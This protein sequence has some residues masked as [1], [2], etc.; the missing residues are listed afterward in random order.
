MIDSESINQT[1]QTREN[2]ITGFLEQFGKFMG[3][4]IQRTVEVTGRQAHNTR[5]FLR[6]THETI[7][8]PLMEVGTSAQE[9]LTTSLHAGRELA[10]AIGEVIKQFTANA[11]RTITGEDL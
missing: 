3:T 4:A 5:D 7:M 11:F 8:P 1:A 6:D 9:L 2:I 10:W